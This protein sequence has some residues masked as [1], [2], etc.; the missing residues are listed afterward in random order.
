MTPQTTSSAT[1][2][3]SSSLSLLPPAVP[4]PLPA[5]GSATRRSPEQFQTASR[6]YW[7]DEEDDDAVYSIFLKRVRY[8]SP[9]TMASSHALA[10]S[11]SFSTFDTASNTLAVPGGGVSY[12]EWQTVKV[13]NLKAGTLDRILRCL[14]T[15]DNE[16]DS[17]HV[18]IFLDTY[19]E[20]S[21]PVDVVQQL[22][23]QLVEARE[24]H[25]PRQRPLR[26]LLNTLLDSYPEDFTS[27]SLVELDDSIMLMMEYS[28]KHQ[29]IDFRHKLIQRIAALNSSSRLPHLEVLE[30]MQAEPS[31]FNDPPSNFSCAEDLLNYSDKAV[32]EQL[33]LL[34]AVLLKRLRPHECLARERASRKTPD[35]VQGTICHF[36]AVCARVESTLLGNLNMCSSLRL[37]LL[38]KWIDVAQFLL[39]LKNFSSLNAVISALQAEPVFRLER[40]WSSL[41]ADK[42]AKFQQLAAVFKTDWSAKRNEFQ[43]GVTTPPSSRSYAGFPKEPTALKNAKRIN[44]RR[45]HSDNPG[46]VH[47]MIPYLGKFLTDLV[48]LDTA[49]PNEVTN[50]SGVRLLNFEKCRK[51]FEILAQIRLCQSAAA[52][53]LIE[54]HDHFRYWFY[55]SLRVLDSEDCFNNSF[56][57]EPP[58]TS[59]TSEVSDSSEGRK[60]NALL[61]GLTNTLRRMVSQENLLNYTP[62]LTVTRKNSISSSQSLDYRRATSATESSAAATKS[63]YLSDTFCILKIS[64]DGNCGSSVFYSGVNLYKGI[65]VNDNEKTQTV[66][67]AA[68]EKHGKQYDDP[69]CYDLVQVLSQDKE[70][71]I[72]FDA[73]VFYAINSTEVDLRFTLRRKS[74]PL[75]FCQ[76]PSS[77]TVS[78]S[79]P[80]QR[81]VSKHRSPKDTLEKWSI[82]SLRRS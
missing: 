59:S 8:G 57:I 82:K 58:L 74:S 17:G 49:L 39:V 40:L 27:G 66:I 11:A 9:G 68:L 37:R 61:N 54:P 30:W 42:M 44:H 33:T 45:S 25:S 15:P 20:I 43:A 12:L 35:T 16:L 50:K 46:T 2:V 67:K 18:N 72:P 63:P 77:H 34:D 53:Y 75:Q 73:T 6:R 65:L 76:S 14:I 79:Q 69:N 78:S 80:K 41:P 23:R 29:D 36:N 32:A 60:R 21:N 1:M 28:E 22:L 51:E 7:M 71:V 81:S 48:M 24:E 19:R 52:T 26:Q 10:S 5:N 55:K 62:L 70:F 38:I 56:I 4:A 47:G 64:L 3:S 31:P 13:R